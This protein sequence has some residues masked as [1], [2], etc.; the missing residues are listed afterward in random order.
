MWAAHPERT[1]CLVLKQ[2]IM[3]RFLIVTQSAWHLHFKARWFKLHYLWL[4]TFL[5]L[6]SMF[7]F[8][9]SFMLLA[10]IFNTYTNYSMLRN[11][12][13]KNDGK[14]MT[15]ADFLHLASNATSIS[16]VLINIKV[17]LCYPCL[18]NHLIFYFILN[19]DIKKMYPFGG[20]IITVQDNKKIKYPSIWIII[21]SG[22]TIKWKTT[23]VCFVHSCLSSIL[24][25]ICGKFYSFAYEKLDLGYG[26]YPLGQIGR[27]NVAK[28]GKGQVGWKLTV[29][30]INKTAKRSIS[31]NLNSTLILDCSH[32]WNTNYFKVFKNL[33]NPSQAQRMVDLLSYLPD[34]PIWGTPQE[35]CCLWITFLFNK[36]KQLSVH[37]KT[38]LTWFLWQ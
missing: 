12:K 16:G 33:G 20:W 19:Y 5:L 6:I 23:R 13:F 24:N 31:S 1:V 35:F 17:S 28:K 14:L 32:I 8:L 4:S 26:I 30:L 18:S 7:L 22:Y 11:P 38:P 3:T 27:Q 25:S 21:S 34:L 15:L 36:R 37:C 29:R 2:L 9:F 10:A